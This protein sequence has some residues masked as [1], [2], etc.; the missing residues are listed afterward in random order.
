[1]IKKFLKSNVFAI[2]IMATLIGIISYLPVLYHVYNTKHTEDFPIITLYIALLS[3]IL[4]MVYGLIKGAY[5]SFIS[6][7]L[8]FMIY[9]YIFYVKIMN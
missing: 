1:M 3:N 6:G 2:G 8:Y 9:A 7:I 4:W 5:A